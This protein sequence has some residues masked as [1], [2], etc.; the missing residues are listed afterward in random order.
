MVV[1]FTDITERKR[2][3]ESLLQS[4]KLESLGVLAGGIAHDF[5]NILTG[6]IG[7]SRLVLETLA[8]SD[9]NRGLLSEVVSAG[10]RAADLTRQMLAFAGKGQF[11]IEP[12]DLSKAIQDVGELLAATLPKPAQAEA[13]AGAPPGPGRSRRAPDPA[14]HLQPRDQRRRGDRRAAG[15]GHGRDRHARPARGRARRSAVRT[16]PARPLCLGRGP[17]HRRRHGRGDAGAHLRPVLL[18]QVHRTRLGLAA[19]LGIARAHHGAIRVESAPGKGSRFELLLPVTQ[20]RVFHMPP[21]KELGKPA[22]HADRP[23]RGRRRD[24]PRHRAQMLERRATAWCWPRTASRR[25]SSSASARAEIAARAARPDDA[26]NGRRG[27]SP[28]PA[29]RSAHEVPILVPSGYPE[30]SVARRFAATRVAGFL[31]KPYTSAQ[32]VERVKEALG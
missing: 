32:L 23:G 16:R 1:T 10:E 18:H 4:T 22:R 17:G 31:R 5:N 30:R 2:S 20:S 21:P 19:A 25:S 7:N 12:V 24:R 15:H 28:V 11:V 14:A 26:G 29:D 3:E 6:I 13:R 27:G 8:N 9:P